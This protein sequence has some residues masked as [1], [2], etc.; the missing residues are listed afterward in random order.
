MKNKTGLITLEG[1]RKIEKESGRI[2]K[3][4][5][6][7][8]GLEFYNKDVNHWLKENNIIMYSTYSEH[9]SCVVERFNRTLKEQMWK[10]FTSEN[11]R[12]WINMLNNLMKKYNNKVHSTIGISPSE[13]SRKENEMEVLQN[14]LDKTRSIPITNPKF[15]I[16]DTVRL[17]R[18][19]AIFE[20]GYLPNWSEE[21]YIVD[22]V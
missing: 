8:K 12:N 18:T 14:T 10:Q 4:L 7:D 19:K 17:S 5:W 11:T 3:H 9:K 22:K 15:K 2:P 21:L 6:V 1:F 20:K 16:G 13:A